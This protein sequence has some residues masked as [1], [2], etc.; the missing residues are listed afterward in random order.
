MSFRVR[1]AGNLVGRC[2]VLLRIHRH[3]NKFNGRVKQNS[4]GTNVFHDCLTTTNENE[5]IITPFNYLELKKKNFP[6]QIEPHSSG[7][8]FFLSLSL[9]LSLSFS[10]S[11]LFSGFIL[12][13]FL[14]KEFSGSSKNSLRVHRT[15]QFY[16]RRSSMI[17]YELLNTLRY[18]TCILISQEKKERKKRKKMRSK[19]IPLSISNCATTNVVVRGNWLI[20]FEVNAQSARLKGRGRARSLARARKYVREKLF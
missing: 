2:N 11:L 8:L 20:V 5:I 12:I 3:A 6:K 9:S 7:F 15:L 10:L 4:V 13:N 14:I 18:H 17:Q 1:F 16:L 19:L